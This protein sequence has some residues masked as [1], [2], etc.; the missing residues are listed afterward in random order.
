MDQELIG[1]D[2]LHQL[3]WGD[4]PGWTV[5]REVTPGEWV[6]VATYVE[7]PPLAPRRFAKWLAS[8]TGLT[9]DLA[10]DAVEWLREQS[11]YRFSDPFVEEE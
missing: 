3:L 5:Q 10:W 6:D 4:E 9:F 1:G 11:P 7:P 2:P 8:Q